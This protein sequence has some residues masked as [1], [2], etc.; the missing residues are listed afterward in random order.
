MTPSCDLTKNRKAVGQSVM[1]VFGMTY[2]FSKF[3]C[4]MQFNFKLLSIMNHQVYL[5]P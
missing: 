3:L 4:N 1:N 5:T 2:K